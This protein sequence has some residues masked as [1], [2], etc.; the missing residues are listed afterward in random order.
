ML[1]Y[2][3]HSSDGFLV[4]APGLVC[5][6]CLSRRYGKV[7]VL[8]LAMVSNA[9]TQIALQSYQE[10]IHVVRSNKVVRR[11]P[12]ESNGTPAIDFGFED[13]RI[14]RNIYKRGIKQNTH[15]LLIV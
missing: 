11:I 12:T 2:L 14:R 7:S 10:R 15:V 4:V 3:P 8:F 1:A 9:T 13:I 5:L 6:F